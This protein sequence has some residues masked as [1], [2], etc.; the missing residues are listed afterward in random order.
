MTKCEICDSPEAVIKCSKCGKDIC[1]KC[2]IDYFDKKICTAC[3]M[4]LIGFFCN[5]HGDPRTAVEKNK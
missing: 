3:G 1:S 5:M 4:P 2:T